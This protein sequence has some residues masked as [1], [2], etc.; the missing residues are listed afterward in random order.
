[1]QTTPSSPPADP[2]APQSLT[3]ALPGAEPGADFDDPADLE[4]AAPV[5]LNGDGPVTALRVASALFDMVSSAVRGKDDAV[6]LALVALLSGSHLL[7]EDVPGTGKT[8]LG[9]SLAAA[10]GGRATSPAPRCTRR[11]P[12]P[13]TSGPARSSRTSCS[14]TR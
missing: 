14:S 10:I 13:G 8:L 3:G 9:K 4:T 11:P 6:R 7:V 5:V 12:V 2:G 1:M